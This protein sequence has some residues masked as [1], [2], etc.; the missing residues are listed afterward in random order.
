MLTLTEA[1][2]AQ[3]AKLL[4]DE[5]LSAVARLIFRKDDF[6]L[7]LDYVLPGDVTYDHDGRTVLVLD[8]QVLQ[9][10]E[11]AT[12]DTKDTGDGTELT[13]GPLYRAK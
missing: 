12:L 2:G 9:L 11:D 7:V 4:A 8:E 10:L 5:D 6:D 3:L 1:A 13:L